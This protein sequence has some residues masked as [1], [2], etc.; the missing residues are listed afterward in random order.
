MSITLTTGKLV[1]VNGATVENNT[2]GEDMNLD[3]DY[4]GNTATF[5]L[6]TGTIQ[7]GNLNAGV[8]GDTVSVT[9]NLLTG[10][11]QSTNGVSGTI[12]STQLQQFNTL[13]KNVRNGNE[14]FVAATAI[15][16][17]TQVPW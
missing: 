17:G 13:L 16:P 5:T 6:K 1:Q 12:T 9:L 4:L 8:Y 7:A 14:A 11:Y 3:V 10:A 15:M 2:T